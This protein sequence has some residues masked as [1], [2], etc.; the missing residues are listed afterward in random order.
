MPYVDVFNW[1]LCYERE[2]NRLI[3]SIW[4]R[5]KRYK[6]IGPVLPLYSRGSKGSN[7]YDSF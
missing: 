3:L 7:N 1:M 4:D 6:I 2:V 5:K